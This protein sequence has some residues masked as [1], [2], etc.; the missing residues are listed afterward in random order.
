MALDRAATSLGREI[1][2]TGASWS[3]FIV[4]APRMASFCGSLKNG[5]GGSCRVCP[6]R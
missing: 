3:N 2:G 1:Q 6:A 4:L 5:A